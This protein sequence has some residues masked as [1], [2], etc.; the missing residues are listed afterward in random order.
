MGGAPRLAALDP[1]TVATDWHVRALAAEF[2]GGAGARRSAAD[3]GASKA[4]CRARP[5]VRRNRTHARRVSAEVRA[6]VRAAEPR[7]DRGCLAFP[8]PPGRAAD[9][10]HSS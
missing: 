5:S 1:A 2:F 7:R 3:A 9:L 10:P 6:G 8:V 4:R